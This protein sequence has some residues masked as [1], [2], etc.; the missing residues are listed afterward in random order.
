M[1]DI[2]IRKI[3][4]AGRITFNR[5]DAL[6]AMTYDMC[7]AIKQAM[8]TWRNDPEVK[9]IVIDAAGDRA[10]C[11]GGD[12]AQLYATGTKGDY[13]FGHRFWADEYR[14]N[15]K[16]FSYPK[17][18]ISFM[19]GYTMGGGVGIGCHG[20]HRIV[21]E[22][23]KIA[24]PECGIGLIPDV[25]GSLILALAPG[26]LG[27]YLATTGYRMTAANAV[28]AGFADL[29]IPQDRWPKAI[30]ALEAGAAPDT[31][32]TFATDPGPSGLEAQQKT[33]DAF[34][35]GDRLDDILVLLR[36]ADS[37]FATE[38]LKL[39]SRNAP[40]SMAATVE[41]LHR[42]RGPSISMA[43]ALELEYR[44]TSRAMEHGEFLEGIRATIIEKDGKPDWQ[45]ADGHVP[46]VAVSKMLMPMGENTLKLEK[47]L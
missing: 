46:V 20:T 39:F 3:H 41:V 28:Y 25:G 19:Q 7:L 1:T 44:F 24:M 30:K 11:A 12:I 6:N 23:S 15:A 14:L 18:V 26:R 32:S 33:I 17:P 2:L 5:P 36:R 22:S 42:L 47:T 45:F 43:K 37:D 8:D 40:L 34:F 16:I 9:H 13:A 4:Q 27:E 29:H 31:L 21:G 38:T 35:A 10:F